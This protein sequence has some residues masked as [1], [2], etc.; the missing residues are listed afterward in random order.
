MGVG[1]G[2][3][4]FQHILISDFAPNKKIYKSK[5]GS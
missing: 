2:A 4:T 3:G 1:D 5:D